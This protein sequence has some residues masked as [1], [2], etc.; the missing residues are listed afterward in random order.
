[1]SVAKNSFGLAPYYDYKVVNPNRGGLDANYIRCATASPTKIIVFGEVRSGAGTQISNG[2]WSSSNAISWSRITS[3]PNTALY[4]VAYG[5]N[6][7][8][9]VG[10]AGVIYTSPGTDGT[11]WT[12]RTKA[13]S[14]GNNFHFVRFAGGYFI[15][16]QQTGPIQSSTDGITWTQNASSGYVTLIDADNN[17]QW[18]VSLAFD[19]NTWILFNGHTSTTANNRI[20]FANSS[21]ITG[22]TFNQPISSGA[23]LRYARSDI[24]DG[25]GAFVQSTAATWTGISRI[26]RINF[27]NIDGAFQTSN[28]DSSLTSNIRFASLQNVGSYSSSSLADGTIYN[29]TYAWNGLMYDDGWY[30]V[31]YPA[32]V[33]SQRT[34]SVSATDYYGIGVKTY[35]ETDAQVDIAGTYAQKKKALLPGW[36]CTTSEAQV[37]FT[38]VREFSSIVNGKRIVLLTSDGG[39]NAGGAI[40]VVG[41]RAFR[42]VKTTIDYLK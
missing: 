42:P 12:A 19:K 2:L 29:Y 13:G 9:A 18:D 15:A 6:T 5:N 30:T 34:N 40:S 22:T 25:L 41:T 10:A 27:G 36:L 32:A 14:S 23:V 11:T 28:F 16:G 20:W 26:Q 4:D 24:G 31:M 39:V 38:K 8:V 33:S 3:A 7:F 21:S 17:G 37:F 1:M 35:H